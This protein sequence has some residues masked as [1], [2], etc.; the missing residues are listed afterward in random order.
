MRKI[1]REVTPKNPEDRR[2]ADYPPSPRLR[3]AGSGCHGLESCRRG[4]LDFGWR[5]TQT[6]DNCYRIC[7]SAGR[8][9]PDLSER[10][11]IRIIRAR[12]AVASCEGG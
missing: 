8:A 11:Y 10:S 2:T 6:P 12:L 3:R 9:L 4:H 5:L 7:N 1:R